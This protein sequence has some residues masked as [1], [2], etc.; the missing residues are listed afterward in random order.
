[1]EKE[2]TQRARLRN[3]TLMLWR[4][5]AVTTKRAELTRPDGGFV[6]RVDPCNRTV[7]ERG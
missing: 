4:R 3:Q 2:L 6:R 7:C 1:M 5:A